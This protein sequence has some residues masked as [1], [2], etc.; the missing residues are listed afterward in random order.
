MGSGGQK[1]RV[2]FTALSLMKPHI[3]MLDEPTNHLDVESVEALID[4]INNYDGGIILVTHDARLI[5]DVNCDLWV[6]NQLQY[7]EGPS[8]SIWKYERGFDGYKAD[9]LEKLAEREAEVDRLMAKRAQAREEKRKQ[10]G[11][12]GKEDREKKAKEINVEK[13][14]AKPKQ[15]VVEEEEEETSEEEVP[16]PKA[17]AKAKSRVSDKNLEESEE[18]ESDEESEEA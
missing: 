1:A 9:V 11:I 5:Q 13:E 8:S 10:F 15:K 3:I 4:A 7:D 18:D 6:V 12:A 2:A 17:K 14:P 16:A